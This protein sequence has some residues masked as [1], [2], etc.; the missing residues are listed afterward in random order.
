MVQRLRRRVPNAGH[1]GSIP[2]HVLTAVFKMGNQQRPTVQR[3]ELCSV[4]VAAWM[5]GEFGGE[6]GY[7]YVWLSPFT[8]HLEQSQYC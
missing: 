6:W 4:Y 7:A 5:G 1:L 8:A 3:R 2:A